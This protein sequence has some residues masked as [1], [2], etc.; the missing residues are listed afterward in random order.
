MKNI[1]VWS[2][3]IAS[4]CILTEMSSLDTSYYDYSEVTEN[5]KSKP[6]LFGGCCPRYT[7]TYILME[8]RF[9]LQRLTQ[10]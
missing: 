1:Q 10:G 6:Y 5:D 4:V 2:T 7:F 8:L 9:G 3:I